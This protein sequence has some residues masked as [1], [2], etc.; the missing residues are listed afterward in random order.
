LIDD[1]NNEPETDEG[2][3]ILSNKT[4]LIVEDIE[5]NYTLIKT[6]LYTKSLEIIRAN[7]GV[8]AVNICTNRENIHLVLMDLRMPEMDG[9]EATKR[10]KDLRPFLPVIAQS[11]YNNEKDKIDAKTAGC[12]DY[13]TK[14]INK[15]ELLKKVDFWM[16][17]NSSPIFDG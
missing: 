15:K 16:S 11:A 4:I 6:Y 9:F 8:E 3:G 1:I 13:L 12:D 7:N 14:P 2:K 17:K 10:I 5:D